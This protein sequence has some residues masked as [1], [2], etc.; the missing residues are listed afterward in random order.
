VA[1][2]P[3][4]AGRAA[5]TSADALDAA[6]RQRL[7]IQYE[8]ETPGIVARM[9]DATHGKDWVSLYRLA[10]YLK[11]SADALGA[12]RLQHFCRELQQAA[13]AADETRIEPLLSVVQISWRDP[14]RPGETVTAP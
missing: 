1:E 3:A 2:S 5:V 13:E 6:L 8:K 9:V 7:L 11:N 12:R 10:H 4:A 14:C